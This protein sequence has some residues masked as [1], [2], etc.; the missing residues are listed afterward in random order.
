MS[1]IYKLH[2]ANIILN[3]VNYAHI[4]NEVTLP[5]V[6][7]KMATHAPTALQFSMKVPIGVEPMDVKIKGDYDPGFMAAAANRVH[8]HSM[9]VY[10]NLVEY[11]GSQG[12]T[13]EL[14]VVAYM[15]VMFG[16]ANIT[17]FKNGEPVIVEYEATVWSYK[18]VV[19]NQVLFDLSAPSNKHEVLGVNLNAVADEVI[20]RKG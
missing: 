18:L 6:K 10:S 5:S 7:Y 8:L 2:T 4:A 15:Q 1:N 17:E 20:A 19:A 3:G 11:D 9:Q 16:G 14:S 12:R 13:T